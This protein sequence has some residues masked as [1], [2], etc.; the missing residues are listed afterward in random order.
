MEVCNMKKSNN[1]LTQKELSNIFHISIDT[2][3]KY[4]KRGRELGLCS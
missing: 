2:V 4:L 3:K 1:K